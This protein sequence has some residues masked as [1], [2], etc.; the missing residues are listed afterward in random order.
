[1]KKIRCLVMILITAGIVFGCSKNDS[2]QVIN[3]ADK[4]SSSSNEHGKVVASADGKSGSVEAMPVAAKPAEVVTVPDS[5]KGAWKSVSITVLSKQDNKTEIITVPIGSQSDIAGTKLKISVRYFLPEFAMDGL[6]ITS[7]S[8]KPNNPA[9][10][11]TV[12]EDGK[13]I[14]GG[15]IFALYPNLRRFEHPAIGL[16]LSG[17]N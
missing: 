8:N 6:N 5:V 12:T 11:I 15:W 9:A 3:E 7:A 2:K 4:P 10:Y 17:Y 16:T 14:Y 13:E 1:M